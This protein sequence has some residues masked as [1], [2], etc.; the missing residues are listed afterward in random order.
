METGEA[1]WWSDESGSLVRLN[2][3]TFK[4]FIEYNYPTEIDVWFL[5]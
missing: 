2:F 1:S 4:F 3:A 5:A